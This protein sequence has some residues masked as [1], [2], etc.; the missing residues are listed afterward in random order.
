MTGPDED[1]PLLVFGGPLSNFDALQALMAEAARRGIPPRN[2]ICT[3]DITGYGAEPE[4]CAAYLRDHAIA[5][6]MGNVEE[7]LGAGADDC[8]CNFVEGSTC[9]ALSSAWYGFAR[10]QVSAASRNWMAG[11]PRNLSFAIAGQRAV[12]IHGGAQRINRYIFASDGDAQNEEAQ[13]LDEPVIVIAGHCGIPFSHK[14]RGT[15]WHNAGSLG[16]PANDGTARVW[17]SLITPNGGGI[18]LSHRALA[19]D[20]AGAAAKMRK[21]GLPEAYARA[22]ET[23]LWPDTAILPP[24]ER[25]ATGKALAPPPVLWPAA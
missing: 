11:L 2:M 5:T 16:L 1:A 9:D 18:E 7:A 22:L 19:Y 6:V 3:G 25:A 8:G 10:G 23:G 21:A 13:A 17:F 4:A 14:V 24:A 20:H 15:L 12:V